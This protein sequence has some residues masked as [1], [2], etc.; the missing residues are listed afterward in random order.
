MLLKKLPLKGKET[1]LIFPHIFQGTQRANGELKMR[2]RKVGSREY[3]DCP[4]GA[5]TTYRIR[6]YVPSIN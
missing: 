2:A 6:M 5:P 3:C 1:S 4:R